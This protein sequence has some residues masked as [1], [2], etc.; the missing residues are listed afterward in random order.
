MSNS[1]DKKTKFSVNREVKKH[2]REILEY[3]RK[4]RQESSYDII[5]E[6][7]NGKSIKLIAKERNLSD[8]RIHQ[9]VEISYR[10]WVNYNSTEDFRVF[11]VGLIVRLKR[12][13]LNNF[14]D[15]RTYVNNGG[16]LQ[17]IKGIGPKREKEILSYI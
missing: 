7:V 6:V 10:N 15:I 3:L 8:N 14:D 5:R 4:E 9:I 2:G 11:D 12:L 13:G 1:I 16:S 17:K